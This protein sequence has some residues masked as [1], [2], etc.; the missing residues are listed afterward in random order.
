MEHIG[1]D[2]NK[3]HL[4]PNATIYAAN[5]ILTTLLA[6]GAALFETHFRYRDVVWIEF[7]ST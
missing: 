2:A 7:N 5:S 3:Y 6:S 1:Y 4:M